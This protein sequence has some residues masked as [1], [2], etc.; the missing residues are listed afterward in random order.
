MLLELWLISIQFILDEA[1]TLLDM[2]FR[3]EIDA[4]TEFLPPTPQRQIFM[5]SAAA[6]LYPRR[7]ARNS[8]SDAQIRQMRV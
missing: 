5:F 1:D 2:G 8:E 3:S 7:C 6:P 4:I